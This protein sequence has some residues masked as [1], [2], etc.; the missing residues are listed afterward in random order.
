MFTI[1]IQLLFVSL[2][3]AYISVGGLSLPLMLAASSVGN[4]EFCA[5]KLMKPSISQDTQSDRT[6]NAPVIGLYT[7]ERA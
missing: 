6:S 1:H 3:I 5:Q 4:V 7:W 2:R